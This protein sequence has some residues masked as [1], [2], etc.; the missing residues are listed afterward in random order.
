MPIRVSGTLNVRAVFSNVGFGQWVGF[1]PFHTVFSIGTSEQENRISWFEPT[2]FLRAISFLP[3]TTSL[4][5]FVHNTSRAVATRNPALA[6]DTTAYHDVDLRV[7]SKP[8]D[9]YGSKSRW[10]YFQAMQKG[11]TIF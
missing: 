2:L 10:I 5:F 4:H 11:N 9:C 1:N 7:R 6:R 8:E 3:W